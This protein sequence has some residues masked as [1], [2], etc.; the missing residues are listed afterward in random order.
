MMDHEN[1]QDVLR[2]WKAPEPPAAMDARMMAEY[3]MAHPAPARQSLWS[4]F[5]KLRISVPAPALAALVLFTLAW[6]LTFR[7]GPVPVAPQPGTGYITRLDAAGFQPLPN[8][9]AR[10][11]RVGAIQQ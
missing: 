10:V 8:G 2:E 9:E 11:V 6:F 7:P 5:W 1:L 4:S 3:R